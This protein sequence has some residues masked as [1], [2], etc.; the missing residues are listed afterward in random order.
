MSKEIL[1][2]MNESNLSKLLNKIEQ[3]HV[4]NSGNDIDKNLEYA[5]LFKDDND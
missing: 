5:N 4:D 3:K 2:M 1:Q